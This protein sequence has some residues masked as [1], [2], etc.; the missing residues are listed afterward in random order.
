[1]PKRTK[2]PNVVIQPIEIETEEVIEDM[3]KFCKKEEQNPF[4]EP[5]P[6]PV[7]EEP[8][9]NYNFLTAKKLKMLCK[10]AG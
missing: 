9:L 4:V 5:E 8:V 3:V 2:L 10:E 6:K 7:K 1:M